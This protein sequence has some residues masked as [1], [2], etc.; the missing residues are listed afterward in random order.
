MSK[1]TLPKGVSR[2][3]KKQKSA[4]LAEAGRTGGKSRSAAKVAAVQENGKEGGRPTKYLPEYCEQLVAFFR[5][6]EETKVLTK[7]FTDKKGNVITSE[8][9]VGER[10]PTIEKFASSIDVSRATLFVW[11]DKH[12]D[13]RDALDR[14]VTHQANMVI[15]NG[16][17]GHYMQPMAVAYMKN[18]MGW[19]EQVAVTG[20]NGGPIQ[21][22]D[23]SMLR[24]EHEKRREALLKKLQQQL[25]AKRAGN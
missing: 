7:T 18:N 3:K 11:A 13:F 22:E 10:L 15:V 4:A 19:R 20:A 1:T 25:A 14:A 9:E 21:T 17:L 12:P 6:R 23:T 5:S 2:G 24:V 16:M 8:V